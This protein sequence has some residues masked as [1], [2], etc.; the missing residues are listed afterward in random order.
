[1]EMLKDKLIYLNKSQEKNLM[2]QKKLIKK[3][4]KRLIRRKVK[5]F[6]YNRQ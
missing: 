3:I 2:L 6:R 1:M 5:L 4:N